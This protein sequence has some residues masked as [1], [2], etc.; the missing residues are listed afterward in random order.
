MKPREVNATI[1]IKAPSLD[2]ARERFTEQV[3]ALGL[4]LVST[5]MDVDYGPGDTEYH[6]K[7]THLVNFEQSWNRTHPNEF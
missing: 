3:R 7:I 4:D 2:I 1:Q 6:F 5:E